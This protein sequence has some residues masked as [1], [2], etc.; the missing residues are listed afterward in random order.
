MSTQRILRHVLCGKPALQQR[1]PLMVYSTDDL[2][3]GDQIRAE[4]WEH[5]D[6]QPIDSAARM[7]C[8]ACRQEVPTSNFQSKFI[9]ES[10]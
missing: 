5:L 10:S 1:D 9:S 8:D 6:G 4:H 7:I 2:I 3:R